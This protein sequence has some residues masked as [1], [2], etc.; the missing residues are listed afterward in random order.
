MVSELSSSTILLGFRVQ[1]INGVH[2]GPNESL[3]RTAT[4]AATRPPTQAAVSVR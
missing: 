1:S 2:S 3:Q 4:A